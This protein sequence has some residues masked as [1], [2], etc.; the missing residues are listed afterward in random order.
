MVGVVESLTEL[1]DNTTT[2]GREWRATCYVDG[3]SIGSYTR[4]DG[5]MN[6]SR[7]DDINVDSYPIVLGNRYE[8]VAAT[9]GLSDR[10]YAGEIKDFYIWMGQ[11]KTAQQVKEMYQQ[12]T[13][14]SREILVRDNIK[15]GKIPRYLRSQYGSSTKPVNP[16][17]DTTYSSEGLSTITD[18]FDSSVLGTNEQTVSV[19][20]KRDKE[21]MTA[22][23]KENYVSVGHT[24]NLNTEDFTLS[25]YI[26]PHGYSDTTPP[27]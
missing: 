25:T 19:T 26:K 1:S 18:T 7:G 27:S 13:T 3:E 9:D 22:F 12:Q 14:I 10:E 11:A 21:D 15:L 17:I 2:A 16:E 8:T 5:Y 23:N 20:Y 6:I 4:T 24:K